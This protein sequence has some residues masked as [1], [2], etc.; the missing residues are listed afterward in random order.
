MWVWQIRRS[1]LK[2][3][4][5]CTLI[6]TG[7][8]QWWTNFYGASA[9]RYTKLIHCAAK[10]VKDHGGAITAYD[11]DRIMAVFIGDSKNTNA[12]YAALRINH[13]VRH[14]LNPAIKAQYPFTTFEIKHKVGIDTSPLRAARIGVRG[15]N[16]LVWV[17]RAANYAAKLTSIADDI[18]I[19]ITADVFNAMADPPKNYQGKPLFTARSWTQMDNMLIYSSG[20]TWTI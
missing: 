16:D 14:I 8:Q 20:W 17:G 4:P 7:R 6:L 19:W 13:A 12:T 3:R 1:N 10:I 18:P 5:S 15:D 11:G 9:L 2:A